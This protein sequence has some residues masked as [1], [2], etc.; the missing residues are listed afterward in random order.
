MAL[1]IPLEILIPLALVLIILIAIA[2]FFYSKNKKLYQKL[3]FEKNKLKFYKKQ[4]EEIE[5][6]NENPE[7][8]FEKLNKLMRVFFR[9]YYHLGYNLTYLELAE[10]F[11]KQN[12]IDFA[13]FSKLMSDIRY[14]GR[15]ISAEEINEIIRELRELVDKEID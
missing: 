15:E 14:S 6:A 13:G 11:E 8:K 7:I 4:L 10:E 5:T 1:I 9:E 2:W 12:K 3:S